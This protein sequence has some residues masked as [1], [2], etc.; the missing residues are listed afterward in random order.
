MS[1]KD[2]IKRIR[3]FLLYF[4]LSLIPHSFTWAEATFYPDANFGGTG[5]T[6]A[7]GESRL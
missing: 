4:F 6:L 7:D 2:E 1:K 3:C 5:I